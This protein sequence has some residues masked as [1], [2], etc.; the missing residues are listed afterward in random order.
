MFIIINFTQIFGYRQMLKLRMQVLNFS[1]F[2]NNAECS[3]FR[4][5]DISKGHKAKLTFPKDGTY[6]KMGLKLL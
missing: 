6:G 5:L 4:P 3:Q 2:R 1:I